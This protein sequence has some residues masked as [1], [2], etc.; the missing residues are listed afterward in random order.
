MHGSSASTRGVG[1]GQL[2]I[3]I[4]VAA[5]R[6]VIAVLLWAHVCGGP[7]VQASLTLAWA[8]LRHNHFPMS[9]RAGNTKQPTNA[10]RTYRFR[11][12]PGIALTLRCT[13]LLPG[14]L[15]SRVLP[16]VLAV[17]R[18]LQCTRPGV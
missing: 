10:H 5:R 7:V 18:L 2:P 8:Q 16:L 17:A 3:I 1:G 6:A 14:R 13:V 4:V 9:K 11:Q 12:R 15:G